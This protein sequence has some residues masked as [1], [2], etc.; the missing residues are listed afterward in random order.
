MRCSDGRDRHFVPVPA[1]YVADIKEANEVFNIAPYPALYSDIGTLVPK[2]KLSDSEYVARPRTQEEMLQVYCP[3]LGL[4][5]VLCLHTLHVLQ[6]VHL[7]VMAEVKELQEI[8]HSD[9]KA[10]M[11]EYSMSIDQ[12]VSLSSLALCHSLFTTF[13]H[14]QASNNC[15]CAFCRLP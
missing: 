13:K 6:Y 8:S 15:C 12:M 7:Q 10:R 2:D 14:W 9:A 5:A 1:A 4:A 3:I 11:K